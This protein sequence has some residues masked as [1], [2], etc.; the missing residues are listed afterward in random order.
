[1][2]GCGYD[3]YLEHWVPLYKARGLKWHDE[4]LYDENGNF[5]ERPFD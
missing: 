3:F 1:M 5:I 2:D 4:S